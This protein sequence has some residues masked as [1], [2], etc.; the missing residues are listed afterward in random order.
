MCR[1]QEKLLNELKRI[2]LRDKLVSAEN[3]S[4][5][6]DGQ[7]TRCEVYDQGFKDGT[8]V[9]KRLSGYPGWIRIADQMPDSG[10]IV[11]ICVEYK[12]NSDQ[13]IRR[14]L[15]A[16][17]AAKFSFEA[18]EDSA[19]SWCEYSE[20][21]DCYYCPEGWYEQNHAEEIN[22]QIQ[23]TVTHWMPLPESPCN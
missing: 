13:V 14:I 4:N 19:E 6:L 17:W 7:C 18:H 3:I 2:E 23:G 22:W 12:N 11:I 15:R 8:A 5:G 9:G 1:E 21:S 10:N 16:M 20:E